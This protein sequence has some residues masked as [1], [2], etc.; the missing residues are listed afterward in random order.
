MN[1]NNKNT[2]WNMCID[3]ATEI[4]GGGKINLNPG[5]TCTVEIFEPMEYKICIKMRIQNIA[6]IH[7]IWQCL[8]AA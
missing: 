5:C 3:K 2:S 4:C 7:L 6:K 1:V 8:L